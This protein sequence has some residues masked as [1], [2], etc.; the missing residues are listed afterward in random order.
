MPVTLTN[1]KYYAH[2]LPYQDTQSEVQ[3]VED[4]DEYNAYRMPDFH[5]LDLGISFTKKRKKSQRIWDVGV[6]NA[7]GRQNAFMLYFSNDDGDE[8]SSQRTLK[9]LSILPIPVPFARYTLKF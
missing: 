3:Y 4:F 7:Y 8:V 5:R 2:T 6:V 9:Q 1:E